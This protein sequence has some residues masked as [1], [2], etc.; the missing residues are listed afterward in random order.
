M[1]Y[2]NLGTRTMNDNRF[3]LTIL[4]IIQSNKNNMYLSKQVNV[5]LYMKFCNLIFKS[6]V[7]FIEFGIF[8]HHHLFPFDNNVVLF[9]NWQR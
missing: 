1:A 9:E 4:S 6:N 8:Y 7:N 2:N 3:Y 5:F